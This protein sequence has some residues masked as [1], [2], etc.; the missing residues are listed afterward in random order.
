M[1]SAQAF[2]QTAE[3]ALNGP[4]AQDFVEQAMLKT[5]EKRASI[6]EDSFKAYLTRVV[7][8]ECCNIQRHRMRASPQE[9][10]PLPAPEA[11]P[12]YQALYN[13]IDQLPDH[14]KLPIMLL[15]ATGGQKGNG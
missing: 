11:P 15:E 10:P 2:A 5:W 1:L 4:D 12:D 14:Y 3:E 8:N 6:R 9:L 7:I 13:A